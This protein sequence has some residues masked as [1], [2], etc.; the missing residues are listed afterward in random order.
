MNLPAPQHPVLGLFHPAVATWFHQRFATV[1]EAQAGAWPLI[2]GGQS[3]LLAAPTGSGKT[4]SAFLAVLD[5]LFRQGLAQG[6]ELPAQTLVVYVSPLKALSNDIRLNLDAP[7]AGIGGQLEQSGLKA[8]RITTAVRTG[9]TPQKER[10]AMRKLAPHILVT[11]PESLY[12]LMGSAS[13][14][15]GLA[16]VHTVIVDEIHA[17]AGNKRGCHLALTLERLQAL[18]GRPLRRIGL[19]ATQRPVE[20]VARFLVGQERPCAIVDIGH[21][22][23]RDLALEVPPVP[24]GAVM[25][26]DVWDLVYDRLATLAREHRTT[27]VFVNTRRLAERLTRHL[28][29]RLGNHAVAAHHGSLAKEHRLAAEQR[30]KGGEL[31]VL[32]ATA[33]LELG[34]DIGEVDL[35]CQIASPGSIAAFLQ[36][37]GRSGH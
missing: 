34:I 29:E 13:G 27:L 12:V 4:L 14:R 37:V 19:S 9:D 25:A 26:T 2:H 22:R 16:N 33:S 15:E 5:E 3:M 31:Q 18:T 24:L 32:V 8:P 23:H 1:T 11:T 21:A 6:G 20:R 17:L 7:L 28:G 35:V 36:R 30:L 10:A